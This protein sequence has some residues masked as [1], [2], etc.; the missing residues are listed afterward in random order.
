[1]DILNG[2]KPRKLIIVD[3]VRLVI[4][5]HQF[6]NITD[7][8]AEVYSRFIRFSNGFVSKEIVRGIF[9]IKARLSHISLKYPMN[10]CKKNVPCTGYSPY[11]V[12]QVKRYLK[13]ILPVLPL[14]SVIR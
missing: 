1:M 3:M 13:I 14:V 12:L 6:I 4:D 5:N 10:V 8:L 9:I 11:L 2:A 7:N